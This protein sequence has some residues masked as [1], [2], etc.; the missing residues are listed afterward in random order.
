MGE[1]LYYGAILGEMGDLVP[2][3]KTAVFIPAVECY[4]HGLTTGKNAPFKSGSIKIIAIYENDKRD[5]EWDKS[6]NFI[7][8]MKQGIPR[9]EII[10]VAVMATYIDNDN[11]IGE[12]YDVDRLIQKAEAHS[13]SYQSYLEERRDF[14]TMKGEGKTKVD[15]EGNHYYVKKIEYTKNGKDKSWE[16]KIYEKDI[17]N[18]Y[19][20][21]DRP[22]M[23]R[24]AAGKSFFRPFMKT[25]NA[26]AMAREWE[27]EP[28]GQ[29]RDD[30]ADDVI[31]KAGEQFTDIG[32][33]DN[34]KDAEIVDGDGALFDEE[35]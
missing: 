7:F 20:G 18:P 16:K 29:S 5:V 1:A 17:R 8:T 35:E 22:E 25:R 27:N 23:L 9:G 6:G 10:A 34:I 12:V 24:K 4:E 21:A 30:A 2:Y 31:K 11:I 26:A 15:G 13:K 28:E 32:N 19:D 14:E 3:G 33:V